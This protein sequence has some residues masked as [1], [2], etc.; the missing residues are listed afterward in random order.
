MASAARVGVAAAVA[1]SA[2]VGVV[3]HLTV[4]S[5]AGQARL[6]AFAVIFAAGLLARTVLFLQGSGD[7]GTVHDNVYDLTRYGSLT[8]QTE[9]GIVLAAMLGWD[10]RPSLE[11]IVASAGYLV[12][13]VYLF[14]R[15]SSARRVT[16][17]ELPARLRAA[18]LDR[19]RT[20]ESRRVSMS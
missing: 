10:Q 15:R 4:G 20:S 18:R 19:S 7:L 3:V 17:I 2:A 12:P 16:P 1:M 8:Q 14:L 6:R 9:V 11:Q 5:L 13:I